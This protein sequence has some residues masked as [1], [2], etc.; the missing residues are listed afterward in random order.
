MGG[1]IHFMNPSYITLTTLQIHCQMIKQLQTLNTIKF[2][3]NYQT[4]T[5]IRSIIANNWYYHTNVIKVTSHS[6]RETIFVFHFA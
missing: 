3:L 4:I 5:N 2:F 1:Y 6:F